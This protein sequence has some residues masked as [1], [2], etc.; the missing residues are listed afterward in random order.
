MF[1]LTK[2]ADTPT[3]KNVAIAGRFLLLAQIG[4]FRADQFLAAR[5]GG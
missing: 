1:Y 2:F 4:A 5:K 3:L